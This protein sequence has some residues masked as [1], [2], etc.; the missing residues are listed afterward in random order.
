MVE[1]ESINA[2]ITTG[3]VLAILFPM[4]SCL[5]ATAYCLYKKRNKESTTA[6][7]FNIPRSRSNSRVRLNDSNLYSNEQSPIE[8][9]NRVQSPVSDTSSLASN[10]VKRNYEKT[11]RTNEPLP[12]KPDYEW[13]E[14]DFDLSPEGSEFDQKSPVMDNQPPE[15]KWNYSP[16]SERSPTDFKPPSTSPGGSPYSS[17][18]EPTKPKPQPMRMMSDPDYMY[19][20]P[21]N[22]S[23]DTLDSGLGHYD[24]NEHRPYTMY[25][26]EYPTINEKLQT[27]SSQPILNY[28][29]DD[30]AQVVKP[31]KTQKPIASLSSKITAV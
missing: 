23:T 27:S 24:K 11:Y 7:E 6:W 2:G 9:P 28:A 20:P 26:P 19:I 21:G 31:K 5:A 1:Y 29:D 18:S 22:M 12:G 8:S 4:L 15:T 3:I 10:K 14:K 13:E 25:E 16:D 30:Y 17:F